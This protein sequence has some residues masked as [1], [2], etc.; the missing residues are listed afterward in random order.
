MFS[1]RSRFTYSNV[2]ATLALVFAM[3]GGAYAA[4]KFLITNTKQIKPSVLASLKGKVGANGAAGAQGPAGPPGPAGGVGPQGPAGAAGKNGEPGPKGEEGKAGK[5]GT[6]GKEGSPWT[7]KGTLPVGSTETGNW[8]ISET[9]EKGGVSAPQTA[10]SFNI[11]L[12]APIENAKNCGTSGNPECVIHVFEG[13]N[14]P[15]GCTGTIVET[16]FVAELKAASGNLCIWV[17]PG[18]S[19]K[20][21]ELL[22]V[23][24]EGKDLTSGSAGRTGTLLESGFVPVESKAQGLWAVTG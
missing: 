8:A 7:D 23:T 16:E 18:S 22:P 13:P 14:F 1:I 11:P 19:I 17:A 10:I 21:T 20:A 5:N 6:N 2:V 3:S 12:A 9:P 24:A 15:T 4:S